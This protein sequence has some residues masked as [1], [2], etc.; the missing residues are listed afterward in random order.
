[1]KKRAKKKAAKKEKPVVLKADMVEARSVILVDQDGIE[2]AY[3]GCEAA[4]D[5]MD[6]FSLLHLK[7]PSGM[8]RVSIQLSD[9]GEAAISFFQADGTKR[10]GL[11]VSEGGSGIGVEDQDGQPCVQMGI[12]DN[13]EAIPELSVRD[14]KH[15]RTWKAFDGVS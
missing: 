4:T 9:C 11:V 8:P 6:G 10:I 13:P 12:R 1:M 5:D 7:D 14:S 15:Q 2:R 3:L